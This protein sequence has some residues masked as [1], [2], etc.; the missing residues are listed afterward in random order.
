MDDILVKRN[1]L[2]FETEADKMDK[3]GLLETEA[4]EL[5]FPLPAKP[6]DMTTKQP[7]YTLTDM[8]IYLILLERIARKQYEDLHNTCTII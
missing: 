7:I 8:H 3:A 5:I 1:V 6:T 4:P 2:G